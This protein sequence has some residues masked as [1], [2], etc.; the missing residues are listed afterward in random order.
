MISRERERERT[1]MRI[2]RFVFT[3]DSTGC[4]GGSVVERRGLVIVDD[5]VCEALLLLLLMTFELL[6]RGDN[7]DGDDSRGDNTDLPFDK[8]NSCCT[9]ERMREQ[10][11]KYCRCRLPVDGDRRAVFANL[12][13]DVIVVVVVV[14]VG[15]LFVFCPSSSSDTS[16]SSSSSL[17]SSSFSTISSLLR[18]TRFFQASADK[19]AAN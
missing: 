14:V 18:A 2:V 15:I 9:Y 4:S 19:N 5:V 10:R 17:S 3:G 7:D 16:A 1:K 13:D 12:G 6:A 11:A 8:N